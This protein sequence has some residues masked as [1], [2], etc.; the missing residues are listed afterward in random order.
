MVFARVIAQQDTGNGIAHQAHD[1]I[2]PEWHQ[3]HA[4]GERLPWQAW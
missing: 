3:A 2:R 4:A 1:T